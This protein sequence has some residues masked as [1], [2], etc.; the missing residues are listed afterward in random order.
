MGLNLETWHVETNI[1]ILLFVVTGEHDRDSA[2]RRRQSDYRRELQLQ[3]E[4][5][6]AARKR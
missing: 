1:K 4:E 6:R 2:K 3:M 5:S